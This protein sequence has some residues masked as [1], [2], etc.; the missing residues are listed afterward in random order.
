[1]MAFKYRIVTEWSDEDR[2]FVAR[3]P[4]LGPG[5]MAH[6]ETEG[7]AAKEARKAAQLMLEVIADEGKAAP[8]EDASPDYSGQLR[9]RLPKTMH[10]RISH[11]A[12]AE[13]VSL[14]TMLLT[15]IVE[16]FGRRSAQE[17]GA[18]AKPGHPHKKKAVA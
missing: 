3:V 18:R 14:N 6:G 7:E 16:G 15:L 11:L 9:L 10:E 17:A 5:C 13:G 4:A 12:T 2:A 1:M 8:P